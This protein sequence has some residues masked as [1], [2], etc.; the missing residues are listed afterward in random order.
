V[1]SLPLQ[2]KLKRS[3]LYSTEEQQL[4]AVVANALPTEYKAVVAAERR[5]QA[6]VVSFDDLEDCLEIIID[7]CTVMKTR[8][9]F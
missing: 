9:M 5:Q 3:L 8:R 6:G 2:P 1:C 4:I 7:K